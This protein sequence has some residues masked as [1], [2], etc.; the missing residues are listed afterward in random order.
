M[1]V[2][3]TLYRVSRGPQA[4]QL[5]V[6]TA[7]S[8]DGD[9]PLGSD[10]A[11]MTA[12]A[13]GG[14]TYVL[15]LDAAGK[16]SL[17]TLAASGGLTPV[18]STIDLGRASDS[19][20]PFVLGNAPYLFAYAS[21]TGDFSFFPIDPS[22]RSLTPYEYK[23]VR[24]PGITSGFSI[25][26][27]IVINGMQYVLGYSF[28]TGNINIYSVVVTSIPQAG[29]P[30]NTPP[31]LANPVW[32]HQ[33]AKDWTRFAFF[34]LGGEN[35]FFKTNVGKLNVNIDHVLDDPT[36]GTVEVGTYLTL[37]KA[38]EIDKCRAFYMDG[39]DP[40]FLTYMADGATTLNRFHGDCQG[41]TEQAT[42]AA[43]AGATHIT[44]FQ[45]DGGSYLLFC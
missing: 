9:T 26:Q 16:G 20:E 10:Y 24:E 29:S 1:S 45:S 15:G 3:P 14:K 19:V 28:K 11:H 25:A 38:L 32:V 2:Q 7:W 43:P 34:Q 13:V 31:L 44:P 36:Q 17:F 6:A 42:L 12:L 22:L 4:E 35:F 33:W 41:W 30:P 18:A 23:R 27:P 37:D 39:G 40:Y 21:K 5:S 8:Q